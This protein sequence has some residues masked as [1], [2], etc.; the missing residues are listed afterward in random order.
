MRSRRARADRHWPGGVAAQARGIERWLRPHV[1]PAR[2]DFLHGGYAKSRL[3][4]MGVP[5]PAMRAVAREVRRH[6]KD[7]PPR[8]IIALSLR[9]ARSTTIECRLTGYELLACRDDA[10]AALRR[11]E[12]ERLG[13]G[14]DNWA[15]VDTFA[16]MV[17]GPAWISGVINDAD[18]R[19]W[20][21]SPDPW[22]R[23]TAIVSTVPLNLRSRGGRGDARRTLMI[24]R[25]FAAERD[26]ML[27]KA[28]SWALRSLAPHEPAAVRA[29]LEAHA[30]TLP[31]IVRRE[32]SVKLETGKKRVATARPS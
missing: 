8:A 3:Q 14:N 17:A 22:W 32:V 10:L 6:M 16:T 31:A 11:E 21:A 18:V 26:P 15:A 5:V 20:A 23:R 24:C 13:R 28:L 9:L 12:V 25:R 27:A 30:S 7:A 1:V 29:F 19:R 2:R 4:W